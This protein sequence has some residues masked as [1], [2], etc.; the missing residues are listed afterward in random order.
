MLTLKEK[1]EV[2]RASGYNTLLAQ[3]KVAHDAVLLAIKR[4][5][6]KANGTIKGGVVMSALTNDI[7]RATMDMDIDFIHHPISEAGV[8]RFVL[9]LAKSVPEFEMAIRGK[10][11]DLKHEDYRGKRIFLLVKDAS[12]PRGIRTKMDI[13]VHTHEDIKQ[14]DIDFEMASGESAATLQANSIEQI[15]TE[16]LLSLLRHGVVSNRPKDIYDLF[17][18]SS[19]VSVRK[20]KAYVKELIY[21]SSRCRANSKQDI[22]DSLEVIFT[23]KAFRRR[24]NNAKANWLQVDPQSAL[25]E[26]RSLIVKL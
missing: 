19:K 6:F 17:Y 5:G 22:L 8:R 18:L 20:L 10:I 4:S 13:G 1:V 15:F 16:K 24:L 3:A 11:V 2:L 26:I 21:E 9:R 14:V 12:I 7:R 23:A 25:D